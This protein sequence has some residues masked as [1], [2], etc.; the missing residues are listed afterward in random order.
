MLEKYYIYD[1]MVI[2][3]LFSETRKNDY[4]LQILFS[5]CS[6][7]SQELKFF[8]TGLVREWLDSIILK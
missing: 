5:T 8:N 3:R 4:S 2:N 6:W 1:S 7:Q